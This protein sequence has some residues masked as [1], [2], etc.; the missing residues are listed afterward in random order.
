MDAAARAAG[1]ADVPDP[2]ADPSRDVEP[3]HQ[4]LYRS[5]LNQ[6]RSSLPNQYARQRS[7]SVTT[8]GSRN[9]SLRQHQYPAR[10]QPLPGTAVTV[11]DTPLDGTDLPAEEDYDDALDDP[12]WGPSHPC[13]PHPN[14]HVP[15]SSPLFQTTRIIR[16]K[17]DWLIAGDLAP[18][19]SN[20]YPEILDPF[21]SEPAFR[22]LITH[23]NDELLRI[24]NP[25]RPRAWIDAGLG[26]ATG[27]LWDDL[28][29][30]GAKKDLARLETWLE[31][32]NQDVVEPE[33]CR[34]IPLRRTAYL[35]LDI[36]I[37]DP[38]ISPEYGNT[39]AGES[40]SEWGDGT[41]AGR[42]NGVKTSEGK[43]GASIGVNGRTRYAG[44]KSDYGSSQTSGSV[45][46]KQ[47]TENDGPRPVVPP[48]PGK[49]LDGASPNGQR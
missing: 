31:K 37:P 8:T 20:L 13:F 47:P 25:W 33:G 30:T 49:F 18:T 19:F 3:G 6:S 38:Q 43:K 29:L 5:S 26:L 16:I 35:C 12:V 24:F 40:A 41:E 39:A 11:D 1:I 28:G 45:V 44:P 46:R 14:S 42:S 27:W 7:Y 22:Q 9:Q 48:I 17:R 36:Q 10:Q 21:L 15:F 4:N 2:S 23:L 32:W 34:V